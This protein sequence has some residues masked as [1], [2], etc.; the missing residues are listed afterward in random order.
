MFVFIAYGLPVVPTPF[1][2]RT[3]LFLVNCPSSFVE[4]QLTI[5][6]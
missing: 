2:V 5:N 1:V 4:N 6:T 3:F